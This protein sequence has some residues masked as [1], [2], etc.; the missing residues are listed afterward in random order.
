MA[1]KLQGLE[2]VLVMNLVLF[3][4]CDIIACIR[5]HRIFDVRG[6]RVAATMAGNYKSKH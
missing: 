1:W 3:L 2:R 4:A 5:Q 6:T